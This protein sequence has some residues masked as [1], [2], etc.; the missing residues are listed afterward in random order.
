MGKCTLT[1]LRLDQ[2]VGLVPGAGGT[3]V[4]GLGHRGL[5]T[6]LWQRSARPADSSSGGVRWVHTSTGCE[7]RGAKAQACSQGRL[8]ETDPG[9]GVQV[10]TAGR[11]ET[12]DRAEQA[13]G[14]RVP[15]LREQLVAPAPL[16]DPAGVEHVDLVAEPGDHARGRG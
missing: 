3:L 14:V 4:R 11:V 12:G 15:R 2:D 8:S 5:P 13:R 16:D 9:M 6:G 7:H 10:L 1:P